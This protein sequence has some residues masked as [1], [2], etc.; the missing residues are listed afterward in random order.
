MIRDLLKGSGECAQILPEAL[1]IALMKERFNFLV[2][3]LLNRNGADKQAPPLC[4]ERHQT[5]AAVL[6]VCCDLNQ[7]PAL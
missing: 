3:T 5:A 1:G 6:R 2:C 4:R 7:T